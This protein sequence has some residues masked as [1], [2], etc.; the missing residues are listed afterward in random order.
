MPQKPTAPEAFQTSDS[1]TDAIAEAHANLLR[2]SATPETVFNE[3]DKA[4]ILAALR[5]II[6]AATGTIE[7]VLDMKGNV[8]TADLESKAQQ[9]PLGQLVIADRS[10]FTKPLGEDKGTQTFDP[11]QYR[12][13]LYLAIQSAIS[14]DFTT[15]ANVAIGLGLGKGAVRKI[16]GAMRRIQAKKRYFKSFLPNIVITHEYQ[17]GPISGGYKLELK[18]KGI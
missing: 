8:P 14:A 15:T 4:E 2:I 13:M 5:E 9:S 12:T 6:S 10:N 3:L 16:V 17:Q 11:I 7:A 18:N 1:I